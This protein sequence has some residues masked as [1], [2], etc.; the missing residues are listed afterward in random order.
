MSALRDLIWDAI[1]QA[2]HLLLALC[3][4]ANLY[5][6]AMIYST[7]RWNVELSSYP[8]KQ[9][10]AMIIGIALYFIISQFNIQL[11]MDKWRW[12][13]A[14]CTSFLL[15]LRTPL[16]TEVSGNRAWLHI[17][18]FPFNIQPAEIVKL[19]FTMLLAQLLIQFK[20][21]KELSEIPSVAKLTGVLLYFCGLIFVLSSDAG[22]ALI[23][24]FIFLFMVWAAG[25]YK[26]WFAIGF[27]FCAVAGFG[28]WQLLPA[29]NRW[30][31]RLLVCLDHDA[32]PLGVG[33]H[34]TRSYLALR[35]GGLTGQ[36]YLNGSLVQ[37]KFSSALPARY[38]DFIFSS[39]AQE[40]GLIG[41]IVVLL[42]LAAI[43]IRC[44]YIASTAGDTFSSLVCVG[45]AGMLITQVLLNVGM[46][47]YV[48]PVI[49]ITLP[50]FSY[51]G[52]SIMTMYV[53]MGIVSGIR[54]RSRPNWLK[55]HPSPTHG[56]KTGL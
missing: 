31:T 54:I 36:G 48:L 20:N 16:G 1:R 9:G 18:G 43:I 46:C 11:L 42:L 41:C 44:L 35:S 50:F 17:P 2:D 55:D 8:I 34:Q 3:V 10:I 38:T 45:Y 33:F 5:G 14:G 24:V 29:D 27:A 23:Y 4:T 6:I 40:L 37:A 21:P 32:D 7:T 56:G 19:F 13:V 22:S 15:L 28:V 51:G 47:L 25:I 53:T 49:G 26:R 39:I 30:K 52:S 12:V